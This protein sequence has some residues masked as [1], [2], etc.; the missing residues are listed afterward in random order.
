MPLYHVW[1]TTKRRQW[2]LEGELE[3]FVKQ[4]I[5]QV[6]ERNG[7]ELLECE[8]MIDHVHALIRANDRPALSRAMNYL[9]G[10]TARRVF[11][12]MPE[13]KLDMHSDH[14]WQHRYGCK[15]VEEGAA[16]AV[17]AY[18]RTQKERPEKYAG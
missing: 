10:T 5:W 9:K 14:L 15:P 12:T 6:A 4:T 16:R 3:E 17:R 1:W 13:L 2:I 7:I 18:I 8:T 11:A